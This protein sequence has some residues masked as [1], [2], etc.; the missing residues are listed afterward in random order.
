MIS[1]YCGTKIYI[2]VDQVY[3]LCVSLTNGRKWT[4]S[5]DRLLLSW[6]SERDISSYRFCSRCR[7]ASSGWGG[8]SGRQR[9]R[10][11]RTET[12]TEEQDTV[13]CWFKTM[14]TVHRG[15]ILCIWSVLQDCWARGCEWWVNLLPNNYCLC[16]MQ[17]RRQ[18]MIQHSMS[19]ILSLRTS[20]EPSSHHP[21]VRNITQ[22][23]TND[24]ESCI[25]VFTLLLNNAVRNSIKSK[26]E[27]NRR[28][29]GRKVVPFS[30]LSFRRC[31]TS[32][33]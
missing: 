13:A 33:D 21:W 27:G 15:F 29:K 24:S 16:L 12:T 5:S 23:V 1:L 31:K 26:K 30:P 10:I 8:A 2:Y 7:P 18:M 9:D 19:D 14:F 11:W 3:L 20:S 4:C 22:F 28:E 32:N 25:C 6:S 17:R